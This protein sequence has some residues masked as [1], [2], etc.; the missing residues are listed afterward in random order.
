MASAPSCLPTCL[1]ILFML[2]VCLCLGNPLPSSTLKL[3]SSYFRTLIFFT[4][5]DSLSEDVTFELR[6][7]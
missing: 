7:E 5:Q 4:V 1:S 3:A 6:A 2:V